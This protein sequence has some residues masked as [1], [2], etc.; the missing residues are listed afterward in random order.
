ML[1]LQCHHAI[2]VLFLTCHHAVTYG[3]CDKIAPPGVQQAAWHLLV[4]AY[5]LSDSG[6]RALTSLL[7]ACMHLQCDTDSPIML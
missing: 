2:D 1:C 5:N 3:V 4:F 6:S 7:F